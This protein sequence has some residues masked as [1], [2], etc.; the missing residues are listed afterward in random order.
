MLKAPGHLAF[1]A[2][3]ATGLGGCVAAAGVSTWDYQSGPGYERE[4]VSESLIY[5][6]PHDGIGSESCTRV[7]SRGLGP[8]GQVTD[9]ELVACDPG[10]SVQSGGQRN[11]RVP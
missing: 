11:E 6:N 5:G 8:S 2:V 7:V 9:G 3:L 10:L 1:C 4:R